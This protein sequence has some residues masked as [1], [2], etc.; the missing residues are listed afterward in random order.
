MNFIAGP[1]KSNPEVRVVAVCGMSASGKTAFAT[2]LY[3]QLS[4]WDKSWIQVVWLK[5][6]SWYKSL[7]GTT[8]A[9]DYNF[10]I[11]SALDLQD[12]R[13]QIQHFIAGDVAMEPEYDFVRHVQTGNGKQFK[14]APNVEMIIIIV[15]GIHAFNPILRDL[16]Y[17]KYWI[18][19]P[20]KEAKHR[21][22]SRDIRERGRTPDD[23][24][25]QWEQVI[26]TWSHYS[27]EYRS[28][29]DALIYNGDSDPQNS[30]KYRM[31]INCRP[32]ESDLSVI[33]QEIML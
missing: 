27:E 4:H 21:R 14:R 20:E 16:Y 32:D 24:E 5:L 26:E 28:C 29:A 7:P 22:I 19:V 11:H 31:I 33:V 3:R 2:R 12:C 23:V 13:R 15:E 25:R 8:K 1:K 9:A 18:E 6:D 30:K 17:R 10:D